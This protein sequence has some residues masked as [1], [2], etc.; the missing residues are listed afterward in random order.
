MVASSLGSTAFVERCDGGA[1][2]RAANG[3]PTNDG[4]DLLG[5]GLAY[6]ARTVLDEVDLVIGTGERVAILGPNGAGKSSLLRIPT[7][8]AP[9]RRGAVRLDG[10]PL[11]SY[12]AS[13][14]RAGWPSYR[15]RSACL[16]GPR[17]GCRGAGP[18]PA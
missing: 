15:A 9:E 2:T 4:F 11:E 8:H 6:G 10:Q 3:R 1:G 18:D 12:T 14:W 5:V 16:R 13:R 7:G 17:R